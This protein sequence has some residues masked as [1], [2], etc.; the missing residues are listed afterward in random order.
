MK[1]TN[2]NV[3][4]LS[5]GSP[6]ILIEKGDFAEFLEKLGQKYKTIGIDTIVIAS[7]HW[8]VRD[9]NFYVNVAEKPM[10]IKDY[11][12]FPKELY[13]FRYDCLNDVELAGSIIE[14]GEKVGLSVKGT[15]SWGIDHGAWV[16]LYFMFPEKDVKVVPVSS[17]AFLSPYEHREFG[18]VIKTAV[19]KSQRKVL[20]IGSG[21]LTHRLDL[22][23]FGVN[24]VFEGGKKFDDK[25]VSILESKEKWDEILNLWNDPLF[26]SAQPEGHLLTLFITLGVA[27]D[28][29]EAKRIFYSGMW[30]GLSLI[31]IEFI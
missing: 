2:L 3:V 27:D 22:V 15:Q 19:E 26:F 4:F 14:E 20:F 29:K 9:K 23:M 1:V 25:V 7:P 11:Y 8:I 28:K 21:S 16:I 24:D 6:T 10:C 17:S 31:A 12:G 5:H 13:E 30:Y 18:R